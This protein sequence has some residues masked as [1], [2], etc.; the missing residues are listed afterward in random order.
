ML[1]TDKFVFIHF[2]RAGG[3]FVYDV[4]KKFFP[5]AFELG[6][7]LPRELLPKEYAHLPI[8]G[9]IRNPWDFYVSWYEHVR[10]R[11]SGSLLFSW[12]SDN[13]KLDFVGTTRNALNL[14]TDNERLDALIEM[15][16][17]QVDLNKRNIP[18]I[19]KDSMRKVRGTGVSYYSFRF[20]QL[21]GNPDDVHFCRLESLRGDLVAFFDSIGATAT[22]LHDYVLGLE[23]KNTSEHLREVGYYTSDLAE[24]VRIRDRKLIDRFSYNFGGLTPYTSLNGFFSAA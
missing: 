15:L 4:V 21:F 14:G 10:P 13:G 8:L 6:Y 23:K 7:H 11:N 2:P 12:L 19:T 5:T 18:N 22:E 17:E 9:T 20:T 24:L 16:P 1:I 3:T